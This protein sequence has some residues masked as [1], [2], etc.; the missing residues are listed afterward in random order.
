MGSSWYHILRKNAGDQ[1][2]KSVS[3][4]I[5]G[6]G[7]AVS[8]V[9]GDGTVRMYTTVCPTGE[10]INADGTT[11]FASCSDANEFDSSTGG[12]QCYTS[13]ANVN[14]FL[15]SAGGTQC[16]SSCVEANEFIS[17][18]STSC[19]ARCPAEEFISS[20]STSCIVSCPAEEFISSDSTSCIVNCPEW[21]YLF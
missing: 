2:G 6:T 12:T 1:F 21:V 15:S 16:Y 7:L 10:W 4:A 18:D 5:Q 13:C 3:I 17:S 19:I 14:E 11:C 9:Q 20:D 8:I